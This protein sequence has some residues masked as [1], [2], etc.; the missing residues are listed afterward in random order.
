MPHHRHVKLVI[1]DLDG[2]LCDTRPLHFAALNAALHEIAGEHY[3]ISAAE[4]ASR[5]DGL[6]TSTK[7]N[8]LTAERNLDR[9]LHPKIWQHKQDCTMDFIGQMPVNE[10]LIET[11]R[12]LKKT[13][14]LLYVA[15]NSIRATL[16]AILEHLKI[17]KFFDATFSAT[18]VTFP[19]P[20]PEIY[21]K[22]VLHAGLSP[23]EVMI[24]EDSPIGRRAALESGCHVCPIESPASVTLE[25]L[26]KYLNYFESLS[27][28]VQPPPWLDTR[29]NVVIP[30]AGA[31]SR[32]AKAGY[33][34]IKPLIDV[35]GKPMIQRVIENL[36]L[37]TS[38]HIFLCQQRHMDEYHLDMLLPWFVGG[39]SGGGGNG[40]KAGAVT[41]VAVPDLT[42]GAAVTLMA[43]EQYLTDLDSGLFIANSDQF[44][45]GFNMTEFMYRMQAPGVDAGIVVFDCPERDPKWSYAAVDPV[46]GWVTEVAE[47]RAISNLATVGFYYWKRGS[48]FFR[49][50]KSMIAKNI[51]TNNE[52]YVCPV[53]NEAIADGKNIAVYRCSRMWGL[54]TP[55]DLAVFLEKASSIN[56]N[57]PAQTSSD[58]S[59]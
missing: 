50:T 38:R 31:G 45:E 14:Y 55:E 4:H 12:A 37:V 9:E 25:F 47:K 17:A 43:A 23:R 6:P 11:L 59:T 2:V 32:F 56:H 13:P 5:F 53:F 39:G 57:K 35:L 58:V 40:G 49:Y 22:A 3:V 46:T 34:A 27:A 26:C 15:S 1:F 41:V 28:E 19:K 24:C 30:M 29:L 10:A 54:G 48:D 16:D 18:D 7:L 51:R 33:K 52:F 44:V 42:E 8:M 21:L 36:N 20:H